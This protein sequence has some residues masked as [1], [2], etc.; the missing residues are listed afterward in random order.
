[1]KPLE[2]LTPRGQLRRFRSLAL[3]ALAQ[4]DLAVADLRLLGWYTNLLFRVRCADGGRYVLRICSPGWRTES[5]LLSEALWLAA[6]DRDTDIGAPRPIAARN[7]DYLVSASTA[8]VRQC[9]C[10]LMSWIPGVPLGKCLNEEN[11]YKMGELFARLHAHGAAFVPPAGFTQCKMDQICAR[12]EELVLWEEACQEAFTPQSRSVFE[13][14]R[15]VVERAFQ[16]LYAD[17]GGLRV[18]HNDLWHDNIKVYRGRLYPLDFEDTVWGYA[19]QDLAMA[20]QDLMSDVEPAVFE[21]LQN[22]LRRG[23]ESLAPW[24]EQFPGQI[25]VFRAGRLL[26]VANHV[27]CYQRQHLHEHIEGLLPCFTRFLETGMIRKVENSR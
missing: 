21:P 10:T 4:Y 25:D 14:T 5:D 13:Q 12:G 19:V 16:E 18:I 23:Y 3:Q 6:L 26:W 17:P 15:A 22:A 2:Q 9:R 27:A 1:M 8:G 24:P 11:L 7:G 20:L